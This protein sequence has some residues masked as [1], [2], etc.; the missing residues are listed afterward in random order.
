[1]IRLSKHAQE[2]VD[3]GEVQLAWI[4][5]AVQ[6]LIQT[7]PDPRRLG[8]TLSFRAVPEFGNRVLRLRIGLTVPM[9]W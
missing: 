9:F 7:R 3:A 2:R 5:L 6:K 1:V 8:V 4:A